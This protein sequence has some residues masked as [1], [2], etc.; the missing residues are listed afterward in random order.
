ME[1]T[2]EVYDKIIPLG[3]KAE[4]IVKEEI[5]K[6]TDAQTILA[7]LSPLA[8]RLIYRST[9]DNYEELCLCY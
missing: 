8:D 7:K 5:D 6:T 3:V 2:E 1:D 4:N 9:K